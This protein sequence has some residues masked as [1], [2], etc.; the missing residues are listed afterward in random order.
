MTIKRLICSLIGHR[1]DWF[2]KRYADSGCIKYHRLPWPGF[3]VGV[4]RRCGAAV[5]RAMQTKEA[6]K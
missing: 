3:R 6:G 5:V 4:C 2:F 1:P